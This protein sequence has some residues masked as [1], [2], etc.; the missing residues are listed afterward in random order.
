MSVNPESLESSQV[1]GE[2]K[3]SNP[4]DHPWERQ[5][6]EPP[7]TCDYCGEELVEEADKL[8]GECTTCHLINKEME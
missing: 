6:V 1:Y 8:R 4:K 7:S 2:R 3:Y 5:E